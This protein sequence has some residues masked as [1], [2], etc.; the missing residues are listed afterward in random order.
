[1]GG[2]GQSLS[3]MVVHVPPKGTKMNNFVTPAEDGCVLGV[4]KLSGNFHKIQKEHHEFSQALFPTWTLLQRQSLKVRLW[5]MIFMRGENTTYSKSE[6][7]KNTCFPGSLHR[8]IAEMVFIKV[9]SYRHASS[10][11]CHTTDSP[12]PPFWRLK[13]IWGRLFWFWLIAVYC[14]SARFWQM[15]CISSPLADSSYFF[16]P[17]V[18]LS[19]T[20]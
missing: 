1:M 4:W 3:C 13:L 11:K 20:D 5:H 16:Y 7:K 6:H 10:H 9:V 19:Q 8:A 17:R 2:R 12:A 18:Q 14:V 15:E